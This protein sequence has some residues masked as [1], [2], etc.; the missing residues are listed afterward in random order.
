MAQPPSAGNLTYSLLPPQPVLSEVEGKNTKRIGTASSIVNYQST[1]I[2]QKVP[3]WLPY[4]SKIL[5]KNLEKSIY[6]DA[7]SFALPIV[8]SHSACPFNAVQSLP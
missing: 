6:I 5:F 3:L 4:A 1:I 2:N 8:I 7:T